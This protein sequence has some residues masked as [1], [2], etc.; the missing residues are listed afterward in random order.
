MDGQQADP[1]EPK[2]ETAPAH[3]KQGDLFDVADNRVLCLN[4][5]SFTEYEL[6]RRAQKLG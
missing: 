3:P 2:A 4:L 6:R 1:P 5:L